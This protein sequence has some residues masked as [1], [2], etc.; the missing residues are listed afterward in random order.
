MAITVTRPP[1]TVPLGKYAKYGPLYRTL[2]TTTF[3]CPMVWSTELCASFPRTVIVLLIATT[4]T[5]R[6]SSLPNSFRVVFFSTLQCIFSTEQRERD[7]ALL[8]RSATDHFFSLTPPRGSKR[9]CSL[10]P[11]PITFF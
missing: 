11:R 2:A 4:K 5:S 3:R 8:S 9:H 10:G 6:L 1:P 7:T